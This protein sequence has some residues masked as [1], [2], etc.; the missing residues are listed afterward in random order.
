MQIDTVKDD[1]KAERDRVKSRS[2][3]LSKLAIYCSAFALSLC[4]VSSSATPTESALKDL[5]T[6]GV[7]SK[8]TKILPPSNLS[9]ASVVGG[10]NDLTWTPTTSSYATGYKILR[11]ANTYGPWTTV[12]TVSGRT[13]NSYTDTTAGI[14]Q[15]VYRT[16]SV[17]QKWMSVSAGFEAPPVIG[18]D[19][20][21]SFSTAAPSLDGR[22]TED[23]SSVWQV[24]SGL[25]EPRGG[26]L[27]D[28]S[29]AGTPS[30]AVVRTPTQDASMFMSDID[31]AERFILRGKDPENYI[32]AGGVG[33][34]VYAGTFDIVEV[35][36][37]VKSILKSGNTVDVDLNMRLEIQGTTIRVYINAVRNQPGSGTLWMTATSTFLN[38]DPDATYFGLGIARAG[39][40]INDFTFNAL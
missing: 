33:G 14:T 23:G 10:G 8:A 26:N 34:N 40:G 2:I 20:F 25:L 21:D 32:Y 19:F 28:N 11:S 16:E 18:R 37:G 38:G 15:W 4:L 9:V 6:V 39:M 12:G 3:K 29:P 7:T 22:T 13:A 36:D 30:I 24:W 35:K 31:G 27:M 1:L 5:S 17:W